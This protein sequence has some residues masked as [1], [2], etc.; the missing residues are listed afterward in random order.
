MPP[1]TA[2]F[3]PKVGYGEDAPSTITPLQPDKVEFGDIP[4]C[5]GNGC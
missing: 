2:V 1:I 5:R 3:A 4:V